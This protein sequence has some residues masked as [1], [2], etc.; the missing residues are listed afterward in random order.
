MKIEYAARTTQLPPYLFAELDRR[1]AEVVARGVDVIDLGVGD[2]DRPTPD[3]IIEE[4]RSAAGDPQ[5]HRYPSYSGMNAF[6]DAAAE[7]M[8]KRYGVKID[9]VPGQVIGLIGAKEGIAHIPFAFVNPGD[10]VLCPDPAYPVYRSGTLFAGGRPVMMP[11]K[12]ENNFLVDLDAISEEDAKAAKLMHLNY[13]NNPT[14]AGATRE[15]FEQ[16]I[17]FAKKYQI[18][19]CHDAAYNE[20]Y[21]GDEKPLSFLE[22]PGAMDVGIEMQSLSKTFNMTGWRVG[23]AAGNPDVIAGLGKIKTN[24]DSGAFNAVQYAGMKALELYDEL[25]PEIR[26]RYLKR[27]DVLVEALTKVGYEVDVP[28]ATIYIWMAVPQGQTSAT[29]SEMLLEKAGIVCTPGNGFGDA[30]EGYV[31]FSLCAPAARLVEAADRLSKL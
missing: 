14:S 26:A 27:R 22:V 13:P 3:P 29:F 5:N 2:P 8:N 15:F 4:L 28:Q 24:T 20:I 17:E 25:V 31:R 11:L 30:G 7:F 16:V 1:K 18:I 12:R 23:F 6:R 21:F 19:V 10:V 9:D